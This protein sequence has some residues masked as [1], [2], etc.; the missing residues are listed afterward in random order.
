MRLCCHAAYPLW[1]ICT[2]MGLRTV[3]AVI[4]AMAGEKQLYPTQFV[5]FRAA[6]HGLKIAFAGKASPSPCG[7]GVGVRVR[8]EATRGG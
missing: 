6:S 5:I 3:E 8:G 4:V 2:L 1:R 7:R